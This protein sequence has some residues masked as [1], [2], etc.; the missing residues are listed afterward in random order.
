[1][2]RLI[3][4]LTVPI[5][6]EVGLL[7]SALISRKSRRGLVGRMGEGAHLARIRSRCRENRPRVVVHCA[8]AGELEGAIPLIEA[9]KKQASL[10][11]ILTYFSPSA[12]GRARSVKGVTSRLFLP[13]DSYPRV[14]RFLDIIAPDLIIFMKHDVWPNLAWASADRGI[15]SVLANGNFRPDST[16]LHPV[17]L[18]VNRQILGALTAIFA[19]A[20]DDADRFRRVAGAGITIETLGDTRYDRVRQRALRGHSDQGELA[21][22][23]EDRPVF[24]AGSTW[25]EDEVRILDAWKRLHI[26]HENAVL[27]LAPHETSPGRIQ[28]I[29]KVVEARGLMVQTLDEVHL[30]STPPDVL[31]I[32]RVGILA[33]LYGL[34]RIAYVGGGF[35]RGVH[36]VLEPAV[37][38]IPV[39]FGPRH[40][41]SHEARDLK[42]LGAALEIRSSDDVY[43]MLADA[44]GDGTRC[45]RMGKSAGRFVRERSGVS[46][47][48]ASKLTRLAWL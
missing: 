37:F 2:W 27:I 10:D 3:Y 24:V 32:D 21:S 11:V 40:L 28:S 12:R 13:L 16:R 33:G 17:L 29:R 45:A 47:L 31:V 46:T 36:S 1:M 7:L 26:S 4:N 38:G 35:G 19:V 15:P 48:L 14:H 44:F 9:M 22:W 30:A 8:S 5:G 42:D 18:P 23:L 6:L 43:A 34:G 25:H 20:E 41:M 39:M